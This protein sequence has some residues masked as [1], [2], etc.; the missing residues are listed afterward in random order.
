[1]TG[2]YAESRSQVFFLRYIG[3]DR[4][5]QSHTFPTFPVF[6][7]LSCFCRLWAWRELL[8]RCSEDDF[9]GRV[10]EISGSTRSTLLHG[11]I[12]PKDWQVASPLVMQGF[13]NFFGLFQVIMANP[14]FGL[15]RCCS[16]MTE[17]CEVCV[18]LLWRGGLLSITPQ[19]L[20]IMVISWLCQHFLGDVSPYLLTFVKNTWSFLDPSVTSLDSY[21][22]KL[23]SELTW[24]WKIPMFFL[25]I[26]KKSGTFL[27]AMFG[28]TGVYVFLL[29][30]GTFS[31]DFSNIF[32]VWIL[33]DGGYPIGSKMGRKLHI[34]LHEWMIFQ[35]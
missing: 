10:V 12:H 4:L 11:K 35:W 33:D 14:G 9:G 27:V 8:R 28:K 19:K 5:Y 1:M 3:L 2:K 23:H 32:P 16:S 15:Y 31:D 30:F 29:E 7:L 13:S 26:P 6:F 24:H 20:K 17:Q 25:Y 34:Y 22:N 21:G 18:F